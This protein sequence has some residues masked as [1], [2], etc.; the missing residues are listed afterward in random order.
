MA[1][2]ATR[3]LTKPRS[4]NGCI[5]CK[6]RHVKCDETKPYCTQCQ[7]SG[8]KCDGYD[9]V[10]QT[11]LRQR[12]TE[13]HQ[14]LNRNVLSADHRLILRQESPTERRYVDFFNTRTSHA[15]SGFYD[16]KLWS[17]LIPQ[18]GEYEPSVRHAITAI[19]AIHERVEL[20]AAEEAGD[21]VVLREGGSAPTERFVLEEYNKSIQTLVKSLSAQSRGGNIDLTLTACCLFICLEM[22]RGNRKEALDHIEAGLRIIYKHEQSTPPG[23]AWTSELY[24]QLRD[25]FLRLNLQAAFMSR[26]LMPLSMDSLDTRPGQT[27]MNWPEARSQLDQLMTKALLYIR[28]VG[29]MREKRPPALEA[30]LEAEQ[31]QILIEILSWRSSHDKLLHKLGPNIQQ[32]DLCASLL[33]RV[34]YYIALMWVRVV[35]NRDEH[36][37][38]RYTVDFESAVCYAEEIIR[39]TSLCPDSTAATTTD[40]AKT[41]QAKSVFSLEGEII[42]PMYFTAV[43]CRNPSLRRRAINTLL[44]YSKREGFWDA[45]IYANV[46]KLVVEV[47]ESQCSEPPTSEKDISSLARVYEEVQPKDFKPNPVQVLLYMKPEGVDGPWKMRSY[48]VEW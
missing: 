47:E 40:S 36:G 12:I 3:R 28:T 46:A 37:Y 6:I 35:L 27:F 31:E 19:G 22:L 24:Q 5:T 4:R 43:R 30:E 34:Y 42:G 17:Y 13:R 33:L 45:R 25:L 10:S 44:H 8:R 18:F 14:P 21:A 32:S 39:L 26:L 15:F 41:K 11:Q 2:T 16:S 1:T 38:D 7:S 9:N 23:S 48:M 20:S 29:I